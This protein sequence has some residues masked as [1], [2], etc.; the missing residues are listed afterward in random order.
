MSKNVQQDTNLD[1]IGKYLVI[2]MCQSTDGFVRIEGAR[3]EMY[4]VYHKLPAAQKS[5]LN[6][7]QECP[8]GPEAVGFG[9][10]IETAVFGETSEKYESFEDETNPNHDDTDN[11]VSS[12][13]AGDLVNKERLTLSHDP[14]RSGL[15]KES[16]QLEIKETGEE[17]PRTKS[18]LTDVGDH[19]IGKLS[20]GAESVNHSPADNSDSLNIEPLTSE[21]IWKSELPDPFDQ[22]AAHVNM[23]GMKSFVYSK[24]PC[25]TNADKSINIEPPHVIRQI[26]E[27]LTNVQSG[28]IEIVLDPEELGKVRML[29]TSGD[30]PSLTVLADRQETFDLLRRNSTLLEKELRDAGMGGI[31]ISFSNEKEKQHSQSHPTTDMPKL[32]EHQH[33]QVLTGKSSLADTSADSRNC[34]IDIRL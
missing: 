12:Y 33:L 31:D 11:A 19:D 1:V 26:F 28:F 20:S 6:F 4:F 34:G 15:I 13:P 32:T 7:N 24:N 23:H 10:L 5:A 25:A 8:E 22:M 14:E 16:G 9:A 30:N 29:I 21:I 17:H 27:K 3:V 18:D 2:L